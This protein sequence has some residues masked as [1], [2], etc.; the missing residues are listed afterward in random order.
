M[1]TG[2]SSWP[3]VAER[4]LDSLVVFGAISHIIAHETGWGVYRSHL[5]QP[6]L[7]QRLKFPKVPGAV[8][9]LTWRKVLGQ[10]VGCQR[11]HSPA[12]VPLYRCIR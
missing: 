11:A 7:E 3:G 5:P 10:A 2:P 9:H 1:Y 6:V 12:N 4:E 8:P